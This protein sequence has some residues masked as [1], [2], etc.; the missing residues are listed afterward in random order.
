MPKYNHLPDD[1]VRVVVYKPGTR[2]FAIVREAG[3]AEDAWK[4]PGGKFESPHEDPAEAALREGREELGTD[5][6]RIIDRTVLAHQKAQGA[7]R[8]IFAA[9]MDPSDVVLSTDESD[10]ERIVEVR[11]VSAETIPEC[12]H[13]GHIQEAEAHARELVLAAGGAAS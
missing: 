11:W 5:K 10:S 9:V 1:N 4:L 8:Y 12:D 2:E 7:V 3:D 13:H 6:L